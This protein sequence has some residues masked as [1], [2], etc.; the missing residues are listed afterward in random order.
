VTATVRVTVTDGAAGGLEYVY[1]HRT[2]ALVGRAGDCDPRLPADD[3]QVSRHHCLLDI[4]PPDVRVRDFGSLNGT[5][6][7]GVEIGRRAAGQTPEEGSRLRR[8][9][10]DLRDGDQLRL[11]RTH[12]RISVVA[13]AGGTAVDE[14]PAGPAEKGEREDAD[15][16]GP[17]GY[18]LVRE[19]GRGAQGVVYLARH[20]S[21]GEPVAVKTLLAT[22]AVQPHAR[23]GFLREIAT[24]GSLR[25]PNIVRLLDNGVAGA[26]FWFACEYCSGGNANSLVGPDGRVPVDEAV[27]VVLDVLEGLAHAHDRGLVHRDVKPSNILLAETGR[28]RVAKLG[29]FGLAKAFDNAGLSGHTRAGAVAGTVAF[30]AR[31]Q[32]VDFRHA[33]PAV[34]V[35]SVAASLY[36]LLTGQGA[37]D[38]ADDVDPILVVLGRPAVPV[39]RRLPSLPA[40]LAEV[41]DAAL[42]EGPSAEI[43]T[44]AGLAAALRAAV[45]T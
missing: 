15:L 5:H 26:T 32:L 24:M 41:I 21:G 10:H 19:V 33:R 18:D 30:M 43:T 2:T 12:L 14:A 9:E 11:G 29:D 45:R 44:A 7:N 28:T 31:A 37:R 3:T 42:V 35:W 38:F 20:R 34:D 1:E 27:P 16:A 6:V 36:T 23:A 40:R 17:T 39:R 13:P 25:H 8:A 22:A 4:N